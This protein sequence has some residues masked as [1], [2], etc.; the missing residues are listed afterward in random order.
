MIEAGGGA[1][2]P[3]RWR[4][5]H[6]HVGSQLGAVDAWRSAFA[7]RPSPAGAPARRSCQNFDTLDAGG[8]FPVAYGRE[9][10][11]VPSPAPFRASSA[12][13]ELEQISRRCAATRLAVEPG[14]AVV[15]GSGWLVGAR[16][17]RPRREPTD[18]RARHGHDRADPPGA[19]RRRAPDAGADLA[20]QAGRRAAAVRAGRWCAS[21]DRSASRPTRLGRRPCR[22]WSAATWSPSAWPARM[23]R[24][25][26]ART[27]AGRARPKWPGTTAASALFGADADR[28]ARLP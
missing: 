18:R 5:I 13:A 27:T 3:L 7:R 21:T 28:S 17:A 6:L 8:G 19:V 16:A 1:T 9:P 12:M 24:R 15:A 23:A 14:R 25:C 26:S 4:G 11:S 20:G 22:R 10:N 2:G